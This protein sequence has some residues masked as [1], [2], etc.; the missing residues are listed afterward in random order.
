MESA[1][2]RSPGGKRQ[3]ES[4]IKNDVDLEYFVIKESGISGYVKNILKLRSILKKKRRDIVH[5]HY[6]YS[7]FVSGLADRKSK[8]VASLMGS[9]LE[10]NH[11]IER[12][13]INVF[14]LIRWNG[15]IV[16][17]ERMLKKI[18]NKSKAYVIP[19]GVDLSEFH[20]MPA[21]KAKQILNWNDKKHIIFVTSDINRK[22]KN[23]DLAKRAFDLIRK[24]DVELNIV[25][26]I[27]SRL[28]VYYYNAADLL[29]LTSRHEGSPNVIK[30]AMAC[31]LP[32]VSTDVGDVSHVISN[33]AGCYI[34]SFEPEDIA[35]KIIL[36]LEFNNKTNGRENIQHLEINKIA[37][38]IINVYREILNK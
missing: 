30:E 2:P 18:T 10:S 14:A 19:N 21:K 36:A 5:A 31:N 27:E 38:R 11:I 15:V 7:C 34:S 4:L 8:I 16:K 1:G 23:Y 37:R 24:H 12:I 35:E 22:V 9:D 28:M 29:L 3:A 25:S 6:S 13:I 26:N 33:T 32:I 17:S 20:P